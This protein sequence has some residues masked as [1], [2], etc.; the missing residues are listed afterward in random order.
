MRGPTKRELGLF[1]LSILFSALIA[2]AALRGLGVSYPIFHRLETSRGWAPWP[3]IAGEYMEE[4]RARISNNQEGFRDREHGTQKPADVF[5]IAVL[6]DSFTEAQG[7]PIDKTFW[8]VIEQELERCEALD[9]R[10]VEVLNF[11]VSG[12]GTAQELATYR[13]NVKKY[14]PDM[15]LLA[16]FSGND[17]WNNERALDG[18]SDRIYAR[19]DGERVVIDRSNTATDRFRAKAFFRNAGNAIINVSRVLQVVRR[20]YVMVKLARKHQRRETGV[21]FDPDAPQNRVF[22][23]PQD[24][25]W[26]RAWQT[27]EDLLTTLSREASAA[28]AR[29]LLVALSNPPQIHPDPKVRERFAQEMG[30]DDLSY[31]DR[32]LAEFAA[33]AGIEFVALAPALRQR[34]EE[35]TLFLHGF[36]NSVL[37]VG[38]WNESGHRA[39]GEIL[40]AHLC[41]RYAPAGIKR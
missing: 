2:E 1:L 33:A 14:A 21:I 27:T 29:F 40:A 39:G 35:E 18:H 26:R 34:A 24:E 32:R 15:V 37:G 5:R 12:Y 9:G 28:G 20:A 8:S 31:P 4:G 13:T 22:A 3:A 25:T 19:V 36:E 6:G 10:R 23:P 41:A 38:H 17:V 11:G 16:F 30:V 7:I